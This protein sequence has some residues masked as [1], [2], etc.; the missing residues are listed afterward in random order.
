MGS[1]HQRGGVEERVRAECAARLGLGDGLAMFLLSLVLLH[2]LIA[3]PLLVVCIPADGRSLIEL[4]GQDP[5]HHPF[6]G[7]DFD[8]AGGFSLGSDDPADPCVDLILDNF[9]VT[10]GAM[11]LDSPAISALA[12]LAFAQP[13][14]MAIAPMPDVD[15]IFK[16]ARETIIVAG[17]EPRLTTTLR[18]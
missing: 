6:G 16:L 12:Q 3:S 9:G 15:T 13:I 14:T 11:D 8:C 1:R 17:H 2:G 18:I 5:C 4:I 7:A 10:Q